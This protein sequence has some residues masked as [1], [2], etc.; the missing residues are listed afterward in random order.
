MKAVMKIY[1]FLMFLCLLDFKQ[2]DIG[3]SDVFI[4]KHEFSLNAGEN[5]ILYLYDITVDSHGNYFAIDFANK[6]IFKF[7]NEGNFVK[8]FG[9]S[10][11][12]P[13]EFLAPSSIA[14]DRND[15]IYI[16]DNNLRRIS[17]FDNNGDFLKSFIVV[18]M[19]WMPRQ[20]MRI[21]S[22]GDIFMQGLKE[23]F[24]K[25]LTGTWIHRYKQDGS[26]LNSFYEVEPFSVKN[27]LSYHSDCNFDIDDNDNIYAVQASVY[28]I[29]KFNYNGKLMMS[30]GYPPK[31]FK[32]PEK[33]P[34][35]HKWVTLPTNIQ[36]K[37]KK[38]WTLLSR[39]VVT[40]NGLVL[41][42]LEMNG[43]VKA[44]NKRYIIDIYDINGNFLQGALQ[45]DFQLLYSDK[46]FIYF[47]TTCK[48]DNPEEPPEYKIGKYEIKLERVK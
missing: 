5:K 25:P 9:G 40:G 30:F 15:K 37:Y 44:I 31:Y 11:S 14:I 12:G 10:G 16:C 24:D 19:H 17:I 46:K 28:K 27:N 1:I 41:L 42:S 48:E 26:F 35:P 43:V 18:G 6:K 2:N 39:I 32:S 3:F 29:N 13:G 47:L 38:S 34:E 4:K 21:S 33:F 36:N 22:Q 7:D 45:T 8:A 23:N 20:M